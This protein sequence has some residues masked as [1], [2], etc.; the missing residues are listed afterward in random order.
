M[1]SQWSPS[2]AD[3]RPLKTKHLHLLGILESGLCWPSPSCCFDKHQVHYRVTYCYF[4]FACKYYIRAFR[5]STHIFCMRLDLLFLI[6]V[7]TQCTNKY[8]LTHALCK[9]IGPGNIFPAS[10]KAFTWLNFKPIFVI[11]WVWVRCL[12]G[13]YVKCML[14]M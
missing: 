4:S 10:K 8:T 11:F 6:F 14:F 7:C 3:S 12:F 1:Q 5:R 13:L 9:Q 2:V